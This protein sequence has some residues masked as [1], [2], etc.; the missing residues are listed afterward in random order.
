MNNSSA[1]VKKNDI[2]SFKNLVANAPLYILLLCLIDKI[3]N[4]I[5]QRSMSLHWSY[6][7]LLALQ[8]TSSLELG[9][10]AF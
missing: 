9:I 5:I 4:E 2:F 10:K 3:S 7:D 1:I 6:L 8:T